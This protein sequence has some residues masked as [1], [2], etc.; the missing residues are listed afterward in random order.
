M[1]EVKNKEYLKE[2]T[3]EMPIFEGQ[4]TSHIRWDIGGKEASNEIMSF[5]SNEQFKPLLARAA[6]AYKDSSQAYIAD[7][8]APFFEVGSLGG[9]YRSWAERTFYDQAETVRG[10]DS[11][12]AKV[13]YASSL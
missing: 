1:A 7:Q 10:K 9:K 11:P 13:G 6:W 4:K 3:K 8:A 12:P 5:A 2:L